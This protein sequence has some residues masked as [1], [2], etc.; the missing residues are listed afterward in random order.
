MAEVAHTVN[1]HWTEDGFQTSQAA[2]AMGVQHLA[3]RLRGTQGRPHASVVA[4]LEV[5]LKH[6]TLQL[7]PFGLLLSLDLVNWK[8]QGGKGSQ[9][10]LQRSEFAGGG[11]SGDGGRTRLPLQAQE[12]SWVARREHRGQ[13]WS[14]EICC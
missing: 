13:K 2:S 12:W 5:S 14:C 3:G 11:S 8:V 7:A 4:E 6:Q 9:P 1:L 10:S